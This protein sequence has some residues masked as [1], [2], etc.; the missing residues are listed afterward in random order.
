MPGVFQTR[1][2]GTLLIEPGFT[3]VGGFQDDTFFAWIAA[4]R[5][6]DIVVHEG[7][8]SQTVR[9]AVKH[10]SPGDAAISGLQDETGLVVHVIM[11]AADD[12][13]VIFVCEADIG[14]GFILI[15]S[16]LRGPVLAAIGGFED[17]RVRSENPA[18]LVVQEAGRNRLV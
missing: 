18:R 16:T 13:A 17:H 14:G 15:L 12:P 11:A 7:N 4:H 5:P 3:A 10:L 8:R 6:P 1:R 2:K 9:L